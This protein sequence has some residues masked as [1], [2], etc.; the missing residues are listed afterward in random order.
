M[1]RSLCLFL[2]VID[3]TARESTLLCICT[4]L[5]K[6]ISAAKPWDARCSDSAPETLP[7]T[8]GVLLVVL[9]LYS[10]KYI[11]FF[12]SIPFFFSFFYLPS[13][14]YA[15]ADGQWISPFFCLISR[16][17]F[18]YEASFSLD[19][20]S[21]HMCYINPGRGK[22]HPRL[23]LFLSPFFLSRQSQKNLILLS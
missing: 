11:S 14:L 23:L 6:C 15:H 8:T 10:Y 1:S 18:R 21:K 4:H 16:K 7:W 22:S 5:Y 12:C 17:R 13:M 9:V 3:T 20:D 2:F 19:A